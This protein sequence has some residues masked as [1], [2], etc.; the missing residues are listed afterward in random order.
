MLRDEQAAARAERQALDVIELV[1]VGAGAEGVAAGG[2]LRIA[3]RQRADAIGG[4]EIPLEQR[5][6]HAER[7]GDVVEAVR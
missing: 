3:D 4:G 7:V 6:R 5:R 2:R 1:A